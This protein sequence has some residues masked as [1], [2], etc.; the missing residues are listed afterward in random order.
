MADMSYSDCKSSDDHHWVSP[1]GDQS[2]YCRK[3]PN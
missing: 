3:N 2:S 1:D